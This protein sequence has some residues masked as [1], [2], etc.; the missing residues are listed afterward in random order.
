MSL[1]EKINQDIKQAMLAKDKD[2]LTALRA[3]KAAFLLAKTESSDK[4]LSTEQE[5]KIIQKLVKQRQDSAIV[6]QE[7]NREDLYEQEILEYNVLSEYLPKQLSEEEIKDI[8]NEIIKETRA[9]SIKDM[10]KVMGVA[11]KKLAGKA[12]NKIVSQ[13]IKSILS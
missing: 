7:Q 13:I 5:L 2:K 9:S 10:G 6:Y 12:D 4:D 1:F 8:L 3:A 11:T